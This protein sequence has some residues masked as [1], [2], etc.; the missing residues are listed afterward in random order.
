MS[1]RQDTTPRPVPNNDPAQRLPVDV[2]TALQIATEAR[3]FREQYWAEVDRFRLPAGQGE[4]PQDMDVDPAQYGEFDRMRSAWEE[5]AM[6]LVAKWAGL[7][8]G[9]E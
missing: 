7:A 2:E 8:G 4:D 9:K 1:T 3:E 5:V 6:D